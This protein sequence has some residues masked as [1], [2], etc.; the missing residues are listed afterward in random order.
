MVDGSVAEDDVML[1]A[2][3]AGADDIS[4]DG[5]SWRILSDSSAVYDIKAKLEQAGL[6]VLSADSTMI[7]ST[8][9]EVTDPET[10]RKILRIMEAF[11]DNDDVQDVF[12]NFD[13]S[14]ELMETVG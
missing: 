3:D 8:T 9:I 11:E 10:A 6:G 14:D 5:Q 7:S 12:A 4:R 13:I 2:L 1:A